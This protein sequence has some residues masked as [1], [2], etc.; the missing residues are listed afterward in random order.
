M[1]TEKNVCDSVLGTCMDIAGKSKDSLKARFDLQLLKIRPELHPRPLANGKYFLPAA[2][3]FMDNAKKTMFLN[4]L[5]N[6]KTPDGYSAYIARCVNVQQRKIFG[7][8]SHDSHVLMQQLLPLAFRKTLPSKVSKVL[9]ELSSFFRELCSKTSRPEEFEQLEKRIVLIVCEL[10]RIFPP[11]FFDIMVHL[12]IHLATE[13]RLGGPVQYRWMYPI[14]RYLYTLKKYV[15]NK[16]QPEGSIAEGYLADECVTFLSR[17]LKDVESRT[18]RPPRNVDDTHIGK[19]KR[20][21]LNVEQKK[22]LHDY[23]LSNDDDVAP[24]IA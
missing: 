1:H 5:K 8:K 19:A 21:P 9:M 18:N 7:L 15:R 14:E 24:Y 10:E 22:K 13:A 17:Y 11:A 23:I 20:F 16:A 12:P 6:L 4:V 3:Y 2:C